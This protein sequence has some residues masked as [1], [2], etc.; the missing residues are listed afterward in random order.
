MHASGGVSIGGARTVLCMRDPRK[1]DQEADS[2]STPGVYAVS[3]AELLQGNHLQALA[4]TLQRNGTTSPVTGRLLTTWYAGSIAAKVGF[5]L[6]QEGQGILLETDQ[7]HFEIHPGGW[8]EHV[9]W[10]DSSALVPVGHPQEGKEGVQVL[11]TDREVIARTRERLVEVLAPLVDK[12][13]G[14]T[15]VPAALLW[16]HVS[17][18]LVEDVLQQRRLCSTPVAEERLPWLTD[19]AGMPW[20]KAPQVF[21]HPTPAGGILIGRKN[22]CCFSYQGGSLQDL[23][24]MSCPQRDLPDSIAR[25]MRAHDPRGTKP[26]G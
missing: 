5:V 10:G 25:Q 19:P 26:P 6:V 18:S 8:V 22:S 13:S 1:T 23:A 7:L 9:H 3:C 21:L 24:C 15:G 12:I 11:A 20:R 14:L 4:S 17:D 16:N 2:R